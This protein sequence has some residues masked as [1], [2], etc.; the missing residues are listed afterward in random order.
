MKKLWQKPVL[1]L[2]VLFILVICIASISIIALKKFPRED[3]KNQASLSPS[4]TPV[5]TPVVTPTQ[6]PTPTPEPTPITA[7]L[8]S[9]G[10]CVL[11]TAFQQSALVNGEDRYDFNAIFEAI[12][13]YTESAHYSLISFESAATNS[14]QDYSGY[15][16]F[17]CPPEIFDAFENVG[18]DLV[19]NSNN[20]Q[21]DRR[22]KGML[23]TRDNIRK[24]GLEVLG[25]YD[26]EEPR[27]LIKDL[28]GIKVGLMAYT[29]S[30]N[31]NE[32]A[33]TLEQQKKHLA[34]IDEPRMEKEISELEDLA[35]ITVVAMHWGTEYTQKPTDYQKQLARDLISWGADVIL[36]SHPHVVQPTEYIEVDGDMK[37][38]IYSM[39]NF[40]SNQR[41]GASG[42]PK[43]QKELCED[44][45]LV[46]LEFMKD[47]KTQKTVIQKVEHV[48]TWLWRYPEGSGYQFRVIPVPAQNWYKN[49]EYSKE[50]L[51]EAYASYER[52]MKLVTD[53][54]KP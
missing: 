1:V 11:H 5:H 42:Y 30:C 34:L 6:T 2:E 32:N 45:M 25:A 20:H 28:N 21:L 37:Y 15:P 8:V 3:L 40:V 51:A 38:I 35:D 52:T 23:E 13:P 31:M 14:R 18:L 19:N 24:A 50:V 36:G 41:R 9:A 44:S 4:P 26:G 46:N 33:L 47:P 43:T 10:D 53:Y 17:N 22:V 16:M 39:G 27:Y 54:K 12:R 48:P 29:Y 7:T 49:G